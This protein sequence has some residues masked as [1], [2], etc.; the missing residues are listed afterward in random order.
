MNIKG[1]LPP[2]Q[3]TDGTTEYFDNFYRSEL[4]T[5]GNVDDAIIGYFQSVTG[6][7]ETGK[8]LAAT[9]LYT[10]L[11]QNIEPMALIEEFRKMGPQELNSYLTM[12]LN[13]N[14]SNSSFLG[15][16][17]SPEINKYVKR[18]ILA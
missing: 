7:K 4:T 15:L 3:A 13:L 16:N 18:T 11:S 2:K 10:A 12:F 1:N 6:D 17:N 9:V 14:R 8:T 5:S